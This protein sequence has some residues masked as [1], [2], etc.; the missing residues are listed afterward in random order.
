MIIERNY[1]IVIVHGRDER[2]RANNLSFVGNI[3]LADEYRQSFPDA[4]EILV[5]SSAGVHYTC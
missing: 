5:V 4:T 3:M 1:S 2:S